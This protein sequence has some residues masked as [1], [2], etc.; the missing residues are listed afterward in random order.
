MIRKV[1]VTL[2]VSLVAAGLV[3][4]GSAGGDEGDKNMTALVAANMT[5]PMNALVK[6]YEKRNDG[7]KID[8]SYAGTQILFTQIQQGVS[9]DFFLSADLDYAKKAK[10]EGLIDSFET[11][12]K[13]REVIIVPK[14]NP[15]GIESL[16]D[17]GT[18]PVDLVIGVDNVPIGKYT[19]Q[20]FENANEDYGPD[21]SKKVLG[22]VVSNETN[23]KEVAQKAATGEAGAA[24]VYITD[25]TPG[26]AEK[27]DAIQIPD[28]YNVTASNYAA[29]LNKADNPELAQDFLDFMLSKDGQEIIQGFKYEPVN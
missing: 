10:K 16:E 22:H 27:V 19:R 26:I 4:C 14:A 23:T 12:S 15:A 24:I 28:K 5:D 9:A 11:V 20:V 1:C 6:E 18:K 2:M 21:F 29:V 25:V 8:A 7:T 17:L 13:M 3:A